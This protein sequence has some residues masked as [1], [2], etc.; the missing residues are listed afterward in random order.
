MAIVV[1]VVVADFIGL[2]INQSNVSYDAQKARRIDLDRIDFIQYP[3]L[4]CCLPIL[5]SQYVHFLFNNA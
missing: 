2:T 3:L 4:F 1:V 5:T